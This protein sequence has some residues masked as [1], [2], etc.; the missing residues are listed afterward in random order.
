MQITQVDGPI[1]GRS[2]ALRGLGEVVEQIGGD[3]FDPAFM[4][5]VG[6]L[7]DAEHFALYALSSDR[8]VVVGSSGPSGGATAKGQACLYSSQGFW[9]VDPGLSPLWSSA[10]DCRPILAH[11]D[12]CEINH[13]EMRERVYRPHGVRERAVLSARSPRLAVA[14]S[15]INTHKHGA[16][17]AD[18]L[19]AL[20]R[21]AD[22]IV[23]MVMK[24]ADMRLSSNDA[25]SALTSLP[26][27]ENCLAFSTPRLARRE[28]EVC[29]RV[30]YGMTS[31]GI[32]LDLNI[33]EES[34]MTYRKRAYSRLNIGSQRE[35]LLWYLDQ[36]AKQQSTSHH[37]IQ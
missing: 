4:R 24:H 31:L 16:F 5:Y 13:D 15:M 22:N 3:A 37:S 29:A 19:A 9:R 34:A 30:L 36:W 35:L 7:C 12:V 20:E 17:S 27:I 26:V 32:A 11:M 18:H 6:S 21:M 10:P 28:A 23:A 2:N 1:Y 33:G 25:S 14:I 8:C